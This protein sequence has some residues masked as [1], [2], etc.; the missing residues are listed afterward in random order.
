MKK[1]KTMEDIRFNIPL[2]ISVKVAMEMHFLNEEG[3]YFFLPADETSKESQEAY[4]KNSEI[5][6]K[7]KPIIDVVLEE[8]NEHQIN[9]DDLINILQNKLNKL[10]NLDITPS[11]LGIRERVYEDMIKELNGT[12]ISQMKDI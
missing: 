12:L 11:E 10:S 4:S 9:D 8:I 7:A 3:G 5:L 2:A 6:S 1:N